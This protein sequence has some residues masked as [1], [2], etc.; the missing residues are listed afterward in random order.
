[1]RGG[2]RNWRLRHGSGSSGRASSRRSRLR[3]V[4]G[5]GPR[6][7]RLSATRKA[8]TA[9]GT[10][11]SGCHV[12]RRLRQRPSRVAPRPLLALGLAVLGAILGFCCTACGAGAPASLQLSV[13]SGSPGTAINI[14]GNA[15]NGCTPT[16][17]L[18][19]TFT[20][21]GS[22]S[23]APA[24]EMD[25][26]VAADGAWSASFVVPSY[27]GYPSS[28][29]RGQLVVPGLYQ[30]TAPRCQGRSSS[31]ASFRVTG[32]PL[33]WDQRYVGIAATLDGGG[34]WL[35][36][37]DG[38]VSRFGDAS[39]FGPNG[40]VRSLSAPVVGIAR[41]YDDQGYWLATAAGHVYS[42]GD[43]HNYGSLRSPPQAPIT[44]IAA[45]PD[46]DGYWL[47]SANGHVY[48]FG[49]A[50]VE[51]MPSAQLAPYDAIGTRLGGGYVVTAANSAAVFEFPGGTLAAA[52]PG[53]ETSGSMVA[54]AVT[55]SGNGTWQAEVDGDVI[56]TGDAPYAGSVGLNKQV[57]SAPITGIAAS[58]SG[59][60]YWL[61][62][63]D[64]NVYNFGT[65]VGFY[66]SGLR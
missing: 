33:K 43:A 47:L 14:S 63:A 13:S 52:G 59:L 34:Y 56:T 37:A 46:G 12:P 55:S 61:V 2:R 22:S 18:P 41:T 10:G 9:L 3:P 66:G 57:V 31:R 60:G 15:G 16:K 51:G 1:M 4:F 35:V 5:A 23:A 39:W 27:V 64:G 28:A 24:T 26:P 11:G 30:L 21:S 45:T 20:R 54:T 62:G 7:V 44:S 48:G 36:Q 29:S 49:N 42:F 6:P 65:A 8:T 32:L 50:S 40:P 25:V 58:P 19:I 38:V 17:P 53:Y